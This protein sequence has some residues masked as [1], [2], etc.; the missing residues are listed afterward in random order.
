[1]TKSHL[2]QVIWWGEMDS[3][4]HWLSQNIPP[5]FSGIYLNRTQIYP[6]C[7]KIRDSKP[8]L[9]GGAKKLCLPQLTGQSVFRRFILIIYIYIFSISRYLIGDYWLAVLRVQVNLCQKLS[10]L[11][12][13]THN[14]KTDCSWNYHENYKHRTCSVHVLRL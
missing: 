12:L 10:F 8:C 3:F 11:H 5:D 4:F 13:L 2:L 6:N 7:S 1:M 14:M 9:L